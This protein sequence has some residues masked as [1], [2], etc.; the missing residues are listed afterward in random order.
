MQHHSPVRVA[1]AVMLGALA[2]LFLAASALATGP[3]PVAE[4]DRSLLAPAAGTVPL[5]PRADQAVSLHV[6]LEGPSLWQLVQADRAAAARSGTGPL[7]SAT[8][9]SLQAAMVRRQQPLARAIEALGADVVARYQVTSNGFLVHATRAEIPELARLPGVRRVARAALMTADLQNVVATIGAERVYQELGLDGTGT[10]VAVIDTGIDYTHADFLGAGQ[11]A[12]EADD[13]DVLESGSF[14]TVKVTGGFDLAGRRYTASE[15]CTNPPPGGVECTRQPDPDK[16]PIDP[17]GQGHGT[18]VA[19]IVA[20]E[21]VG[22]ALHAGVAPGARLVALKVFGDP[23]GIGA[24][25]DLATSAIEWVVAHN[26]GLPVDGTE[27]EE[28]IDVINMSLG[29]QFGGEQLAEEEAIRAAVEAGVTVVASA[30]NEG[31]MLYVTGNP[32][33]AEMALSVASSWAGGQGAQ[34]VTVAWQEN[35]QPKSE[36]EDAIPGGSEW[37]P[38]L[39]DVGV[40]SAQLAWYGQ[41]CNNEDGSPS[42]PAQEVNEKI[43]LIERGTCTFFDKIWNAQRLGAVGVIVYT[44]AR[45]PVIM[46]C[47]PPSDCDQHP[48]IPAVM[49]TNEVGLRWRGQLEGGTLMSATIDPHNIRAQPEIT[50]TIS[51][52]SSR[53]PARFRV[54]IKPQ[55]TAPGSNVYSAMAG[56]GTGRIAFSGTS[57]SGP[58]VAGVAALLWEHDRLQQLGLNAAEIAALTMN[59]AEP[60]ITIGDNR[61]GPPAA[62]A[63]Q[64]AGRVNAYLS[65]EGETVVRSERGI[66]ELGF[67]NLHLTDDA[68]EATQRLVVRNLAAS[69]K[70][71]RLEP[72]LVFPEEDANQGV[73][74][75]MRPPRLTVAAGMTG[76]VEVTLAVSPA[77][78]RGWDLNAYDAIS[79]EVE[80]AVG[81]LEVDGSILLTEVD[82]TGQPVDGG[83]RV[84]V[85]FYVLPRRHACVHQEAPGSFILPEE[86]ATAEL[87]L[88]NPC[89]SEGGVELFHLV[90]TDRAESAASPSAPAK[91]DVTAVGLRHGLADT[92]QGEERVLELAIHTA[93]ARRIPIDAEF[94]VYLDLDR[95]GTFDRILY[96]AYGLLMFP[97]APAGAWVVLSA[98]LIPGTLL[99]DVPNMADS[100]FFQPY[101]IDETTAHLVA[102]VADLDPDGGLGLVE[103]FEQGRAAFHVAVSAADFAE[104]YPLEDPFFVADR[105]PDGLAVKNGAVYRY[106]QAVAECLTAQSASGDD[107]TAFGPALALPGR[108]GATIRL[109][110]ACS[111]PAGGAQAVGL[112]LSYAPSLL[113]PDGSETYAHTNVP[114]ERQAEVAPGLLGRRAIFLPAALQNEDWR[115]APS[116][117]A[118]RR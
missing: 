49:V 114:D 74:V 12:Y 24:S 83:D 69:A 95:N 86:G 33:G 63:R 89:Q 98:P 116:G 68:V 106:D 111:A 66:A 60:V 38:E 79:P 56:T 42:E 40:V 61:T 73:E 71:Y 88:A 117:P 52:F 31:P 43:A 21:G 65:A 87:R 18:H 34:Q 50:D 104:D 53:G 1:A 9:Q 75:L 51:D 2:P 81:R 107:L 102:S 41:A 78:V 45:E 29:A 57:M 77:R 46:G 59:Y 11:D 32:A 97:T 23:V 3:R 108:S 103:R 47:G 27:P 115:A 55:V 64:G 6:R 99:P 37:L 112:L 58:A 113:L 92:G 16:D 67:G 20:G 93:G 8:L 39:L 105:A 14:P 80:A 62:V 22:N 4:V 76:T 26:L 5:P 10:T 54:G 109:G 91:L 35:S 101:D 25:T 19:G 118:T 110:A 100:V 48:D 13:E 36:S 70:S 17:P 30:G 96:N 82:A 72:R 15:E 28:K 90:G 84:G 94:H 44:D 7:A 85:P